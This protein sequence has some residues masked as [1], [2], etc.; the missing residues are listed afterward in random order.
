M[1]KH[2]DYKSRISNNIEK[3]T[4]GKKSIEYESLLDSTGPELLLQNMAFSLTSSPLISGTVD[5]YLNVY[6]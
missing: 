6:L 3:G 1:S 4:N 5:Y 2:Y